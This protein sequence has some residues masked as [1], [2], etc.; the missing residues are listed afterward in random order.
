[1]I[2]ALKVENTEWTEQ[3]RLNFLQLP[4]PTVEMATML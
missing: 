2:S 3:W 1:M 4:I